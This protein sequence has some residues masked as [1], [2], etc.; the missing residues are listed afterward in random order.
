MW[1]RGSSITS[2]AR[3]PIGWMRAEAEAIFRRSPMA[4]DELGP[5]VGIRLSS[6]ILMLC[7][8]NIRYSRTP[9]ITTS[10]TI[11]M[12]AQVVGR[13]QTPRSGVLGGLPGAGIQ[14]QDRPSLGGY[15]CPIRPQS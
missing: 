6:A 11:E 15:A 10:V 3:P 1:R 4:S 8:R 9:S 2:L 13:L 7:I 5:L 14:A 12:A